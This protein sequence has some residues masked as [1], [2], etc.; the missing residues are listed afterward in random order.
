MNHPL[1]RQR[2]HCGNTSA[3]CDEFCADFPGEY[4]RQC[5]RE[6]N[7]PAEFVAAL[8]ESGFLGALIPEEYGGSGLGL[9]AAAAILEEIQRTGGNGGACHAQMYI[10][11]TLLRHG[12]DEQKSRYLPGIA[13]GDLRLQAFGVTEPG[14]GTDTTS[15]KTM[16]VRDGG[17]YVINGQKIWTSR[18]EH[19]DLMLLLARTTPREDV[20]KKTRGLS[21]LIVDMNAAPRSR[22]GNPPNSHD[23][24]P[25]Y[26]RSVL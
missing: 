4:W 18:A 13:A 15:L 1:Y 7:Y 14:S 25:R 16:A 2:R 11:G 19:S 26:G 10:M 8:T 5:D 3:Q 22:P 17:E 20:D 9:A 23:D 12:S 24:E 6:Q 21:V